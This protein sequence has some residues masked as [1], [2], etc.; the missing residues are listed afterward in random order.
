MER[1]ELITWETIEGTSVEVQGR[2]LTPVAQALRV[3]TPLGGFVWN[4]PVAVLVDSEGQ[5][6]RIPIVDV[7]RIALWAMAGASVLSVIIAAL[8]QR[9]KLKEA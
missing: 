4:R 2:W 6:T 7:T 1:R 3:R 5:V 9:W 8:A